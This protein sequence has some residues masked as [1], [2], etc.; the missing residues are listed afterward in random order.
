MNK[1]IFT[2]NHPSTAKSLLNLGS[3]YQKSGDSKNALNYTL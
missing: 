2:G 1:E 3:C